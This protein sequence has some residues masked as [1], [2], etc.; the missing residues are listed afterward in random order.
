MVEFLNLFFDARLVAET[1]AAVDSALRS[2][3]SEFRTAAVRYEHDNSKYPE[4]ST[5]RVIELLRNLP[6]APPTPSE[7]ARFISILSNGP[8]E[9]GKVRCGK[10][11]ISNS[12]ASNTT[13]KVELSP[14][15]DCDRTL[16]HF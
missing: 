13:F 9:S 10:T 2:A 15:R 12:A 6:G 11:F 16:D 14:V 8:H 5:N 4:L 3:L 7:L 1:R